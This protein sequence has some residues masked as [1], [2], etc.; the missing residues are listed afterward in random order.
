MYMKIQWNKVTK[1]SQIVAIVLFVAVFFVGYII[2]RKVENKSILGE[3]IQS[4]TFVCAD[5]KTIDASF[6]KNFVHLELREWKTVY[7]PQTISASGARY[8]NADE[9]L[10]FWNK[11]DTAFITEGDTNVMTYKDCVI[12]AK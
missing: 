10:V 11:G 8:A 4:V 12:R 7:L 6:Y 1:F 5:N 2:G 9:S 3:P